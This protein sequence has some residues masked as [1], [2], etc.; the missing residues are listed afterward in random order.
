[1]KFF[2]QTFK[3]MALMCL[4]GYSAV[5]TAAEK[6]ESQPYVPFE[7]PVLKMKLS[8]DGTG[9]IKGISCT[10]CDYNFVKITPNTT[11][12]VNGV[13]VDVQRAKERLGR[14]VYV[15]FNPGTGEVL[16]IRWSE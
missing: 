7:V 13:S 6:T 8:K 9:I 3:C 1:M 16:D 5:I 11:V 4:I 15:K 12:H 14:N 10:G 2:K